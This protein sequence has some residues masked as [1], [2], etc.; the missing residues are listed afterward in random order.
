MKKLSIF[1]HFLA[2]DSAEAS[3]EASVDLAEA[4]VSAETN[5]SRFG[6]S[7]DVSSND[8]LGSGFILNRGLPSFSDGPNNV[9]S[10]MFDRS[11]PKI[12]C[13]SS[14]T[15]RRT[16]LSLFDVRFSSTSNLSSKSS[17]SSQ[18]LCSMFVCSKPKIGCS[19]S[20]TNG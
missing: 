20:I 12:W 19:S 16:R 15:N 17:E 7:L 4:S 13:S 3:A 6:R 11:K 8:R 5:F 9:R 1:K 14:I 18:I 10:S 2:R